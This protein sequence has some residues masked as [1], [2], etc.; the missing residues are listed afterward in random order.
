MR[1]GIKILSQCVSIHNAPVEVSSQTQTNTLTDDDKI[2]GLVHIALPLT[3][4]FTI[5]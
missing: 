1:K 2:V 4:S 5:N 3:H